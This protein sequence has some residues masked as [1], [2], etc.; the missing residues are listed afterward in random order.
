MASRIQIAKP[1]IVKEFSQ[2]VSVLRLRD[3]AGVFNQ[4]RDF[5]RLTKS[6]SLNAFVRF[7]TEKTDLRLVS[8][9]FPQRHVS[10]YTWGDVPVLEALL[11][12]V[13]DSY[14]SHYTALRIHGLTEQLPKTI[15][16]TKEKSSNSAFNRDANEL[17]DQSA[18]EAAFSH[19][20]RVSK[21]E[22]EL[23]KEQVRVVMLESAYQGGLGVTNGEVNWGGARPLK[24][25]YTSLERTMIDVVVRPFYAGGVFEVAKAFENAKTTLSVNAMLAMLKSMAFGYPYHQ[26][27]GYYLE[28][29]DYK[30]TV[31]EL[32]RRLPME[33]DFYLTHNMGKTAYNSRWRLFVPEG[34]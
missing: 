23:A 10:G 13:E 19:P 24:L 8:Y 7:M 31:V 25:R 1:D 27:I 5:W 26:A 34:F 17:Y 6:M 28:R 20:P 21:N 11:G 15:Y 12:L 22:L 16:F 3:V 18:I 33:R 2:G 32:F 4:K 30:P 9:R 29:A 14:L